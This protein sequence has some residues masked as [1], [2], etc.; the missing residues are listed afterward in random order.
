MRERERDFCS[1]LRGLVG[2][3]K[4]NIESNEVGILG[5]LFCRFAR[6]RFTLRFYMC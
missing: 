6:N 3:R 5:F 1:V 4:A 2:T